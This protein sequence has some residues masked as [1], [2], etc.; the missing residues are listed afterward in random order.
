MQH[1]RD[2]GGLAAHPGR[3]RQLTV[4]DDTGTTTEARLSGGGSGEGWQG[5]W[6]GG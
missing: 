2:L 3:G 4:T 6:L 1:R 5:A